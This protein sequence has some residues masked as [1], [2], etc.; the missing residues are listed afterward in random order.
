[1][2]ILECS[3]TQRV[4]NF[5]PGPA[6]L[7]EPVLAEVQRDLMCLP[8]VGASILEIS[9]RSRPFEDILR[10]TE[11]NLRQL[12]AIP[13]D[14]VVL[15]LQGGSRLQFSMVP[16]N[17]ANKKVASYIVTGTWGKYASKEAAK[18]CEV[19]IAWD[20]AKTKYDRLPDPSELDISSFSG[21]VHYTSNETIEGVQFKSEPVV[22]NIPL[23]CDASSDLLCRPI[24]VKKYGLIYCCAQKNAGPSGV[25]VVIMRKSLLERSRDDLPGYMNYKLHAENGS[26][27]NT[28]PTFAIYVVSLV[29]KWLLTDVGGLAKM[30][31]LNEAKAKLLYDVIDDSGGFYAGHAQRD[32]RSIMNV[33]FRLPSDELTERFASEAAR[34]GMVELKGHRWV[35]GIR[36]SIYNAM[37][38]AGVEKLR[39]FM[40]AFKK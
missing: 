1:M 33:V 34:Q 24:D 30:Q 36:A 3:M 6:T 31:A 14:Y 10:Q 32:C 38:I 29:T 4:F 17:L 37:P 20:G 8:G 15:F 27:W 35:G 39:D 19:A 13:D 40:M 28:P 9:H 23:V 25:T 21:Y 12:L 2:D 7:P 18:E 16:M 5:S 11:T 22:G 26:L